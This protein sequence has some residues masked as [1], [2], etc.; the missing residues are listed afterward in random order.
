MKAFKTEIKASGLKPGDATVVTLDGD[1]VALFNSGGNICALSNTCCHRGGPLGEG[2]LDGKVVTCPWHGWTYDVT[3]GKS[4]SHEGAEV[5][6]Y[7]V[8]VDGDDI[9]V[10]A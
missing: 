5:P 1:E 10:T 7:Q 6:C 9:Y 2:I 3:T 8:R 4:V